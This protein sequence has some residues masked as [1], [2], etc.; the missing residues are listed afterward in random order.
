[1][2]DFKKF[3][4]ICLLQGVMAKVVILPIQWYNRA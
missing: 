3:G 1:M 2:S 4:P